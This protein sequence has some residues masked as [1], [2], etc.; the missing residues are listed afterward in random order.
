MA[1]QRASSSGRLRKESRGDKA[2]SSSRWGY[3]RHSSSWRTPP[4]KYG[5]LLIDFRN[6]QSFI[7][8]SQAIIRSSMG[9]CTGKSLLKAYLG[10]SGD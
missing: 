6:S 3:N 2:A 4:Q 8:P 10:I 1:G 9:M 7:E 5:S